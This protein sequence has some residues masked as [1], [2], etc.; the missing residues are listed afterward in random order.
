MG[1]IKSR[2]MRLADTLACMVQMRNSYKSLVRK[3]EQKTTFGVCKRSWEDKIRL[4]LRE[5]GWEVVDWIHV[6]QDMD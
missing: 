2:R 1:V 4:H 3:P 6:A 5:I